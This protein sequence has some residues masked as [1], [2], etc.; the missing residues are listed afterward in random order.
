MDNKVFSA[1]AASKAFRQMGFN[2]SQADFSKEELLKEP[3]VLNAMAATINDAIKAWRVLDK[4]Q[5]SVERQYGYQNVVH[6]AL[7][8][9]KISGDC[10]V[11][12][13]TTESLDKAVNPKRVT[14]FQVAVGELDEY[15]FYIVRLGN[16]DEVKVLKSNA[17]EV[18]SSLGFKSAE[19][20]KLGVVG[21]SELTII[22]NAFSLYK[23]GLDEVFYLLKRAIVD[24]RGIKDLADNIEQMVTVEQKADYVEK[25][26]A[27]HAATNNTDNH[28]G[29]VY[30]LELEK[31]ERLSIAS[32][33]GGIVTAFEQ[34]KNN[35]IAATGIPEIKIFGSQIGGIGNNDASTLSIYYDKVEALLQS[36]VYDLL[37]FMDEKAGLNFGEWDFGSVRVMT[38][39]EKVAIEKTNAD[40]DKIY[41]DM[42]DTAIQQPILKRIES[43][44]GEP[45]GDEV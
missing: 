40:I 8:L 42:F 35:F 6:D 23:R 20:R 7:L 13:V 36:T 39:A 1:Y 18:H 43:R 33:F 26:K 14:G 4:A 27:V 45:N 30:D 11:I 10:I 28:T 25:I 37:A 41:F 32:S 19:L 5:H 31:V 44:Y 29:V 12:P 16:G 17:H 22:S 21:G 24:T 9:S 38:E 2:F 34:L 15:G 3:L